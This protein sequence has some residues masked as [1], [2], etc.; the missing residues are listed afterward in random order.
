[1]L[2]PLVWGLSGNPVASYSSIAL[3]T[4]VKHR[5]SQPLFL[6]ASPDDTNR[7][8]V[9]EQDGR[10]LIVKGDRVLTTPF[11]DISKKLSTGGERGLLGLA[12]H[13]HFS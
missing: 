4:I 7:L 6:T 3:K 13:P 9:V 8:I 12:F 1:M 10:I 2:P 5:F 11:L